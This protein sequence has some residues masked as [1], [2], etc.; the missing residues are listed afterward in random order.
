MG[1]EAYMKALTIYQ[2]AFNLD[3]PKVDTS[4]LADTA[5]KVSQDAERIK[6]DAERLITENDE[7]LQNMTNKREEL[8]D[9]LHSH[10]AQQQQIDS[11]LAEMDD[12]R[13]RALKAVELGDTVLLEANR[14]LTTLLDFESRVNEN[15]EAADEAIK[16]IADIERTITDANDQ[17]TSAAEALENTDKNA[18]LALE[19][20]IEAKNT[21][22]SAS[23]HAT[24]IA[25]ESVEIKEAAIQLNKDSKSLQ[26]KYDQTSEFAENKT[27]KTSEEDAQLAAEALREANKA[28]SS[29]LEATQKVEQAKSELEE[30]SQILSSIEEQDSSS[31]DELERRLNAAEQK[32]IEA[33]LKE[34]EE[35][36]QRQLLRKT[37]LKNEHAIVKEEV[38][39][40]KDIIS[41]LPD[42][43]PNVYEHGL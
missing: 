6:S 32:Y 28:Q 29:S 38:D 14:T 20:A 39:T 26:D 31:L 30:I 18:F 11:Q 22:K 13:S 34:L 17:T 43:C 41:Q 15:K 9:L 40:I 37:E 33:K 2:T 25:S 23:E 42:F 19:V 35:A 12:Q 8:N 27:K 36:K 16:K 5:Q 3:V 4:G 1:T 21:G 7:L 10:M 24:T